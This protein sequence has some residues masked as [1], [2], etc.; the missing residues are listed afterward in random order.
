MALILCDYSVVVVVMVRVSG[1]V[2]V[3]VVGHA[4]HIC[5]SLSR[6]SQSMRDTSEMLT[7]IIFCC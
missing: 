1:S 2:G 7:Y 5:M 4:A 3:R 6:S